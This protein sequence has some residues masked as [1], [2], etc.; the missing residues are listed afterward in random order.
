MQ[1][2]NEIK[3]PLIVRLSFIL[4]FLISTF[5]I[6]TEFR[7]YLAPL[8]LGVLFAYLLFPIAN[9]FEKRNVPR[10]LANLISIIFGVSVI[11]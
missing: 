1:P 6:L 10:I 9:F 11:Y 3:L 7:F 8:T 5:Y 2:K 4:V